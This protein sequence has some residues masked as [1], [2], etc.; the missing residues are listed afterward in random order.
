M[1]DKGLQRDV[2]DFCDAVMAE[3]TVHGLG[4]FHLVG[5]LLSLAARLAAEGG[6]SFRDWTN[7]AARAYRDA[8]RSAAQ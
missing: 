3:A 7:A 8:R 2:G 5:V 6:L 4:A 1:T